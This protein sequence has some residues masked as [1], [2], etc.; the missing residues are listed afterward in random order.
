MR[1]Y[2][3]VQFVNIMCGGAPSASQKAQPHMTNYGRLG[4][5]KLQSGKFAFNLALNLYYAALAQ[6]RKFSGNEHGA[7]ET[8]RKF[9]RSEVKQL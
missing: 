5:D 7:H 3:T 6:F 2:A 1:V 9:E 4:S 8:F